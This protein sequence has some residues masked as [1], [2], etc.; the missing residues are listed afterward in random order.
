MISPV[1]G[2]AVH[3]K[4][5]HDC[6]NTAVLALES[7]MLTLS[8]ETCSFVDK[9]RDAGYF[10]HQCHGIRM[11]AFR[12]RVTGKPSPIPRV[13]VLRTI[14]VTGSICC[15]LEHDTTRSLTC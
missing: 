7:V 11:L 13:H 15:F 14:P 5:H 4:M 1:M 12:L 10:C 9:G 6:L 2:T 8:E 3:G